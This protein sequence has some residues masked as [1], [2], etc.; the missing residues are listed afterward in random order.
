MQLKK[1]VAQLE[2]YINQLN[3]QILQADVDLH[4]IRAEQ[5]KFVSEK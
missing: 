5:V 2:L 3:N 4:R 1:E